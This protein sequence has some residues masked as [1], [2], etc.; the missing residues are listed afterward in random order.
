[1][2]WFDDLADPGIL[3]LS[4]RVTVRASE[5]LCDTGD[6]YPARVTLTTAEGEFRIDVPYARGHTARPL[7]EADL[8]AKL[9]ATAG[10][11]APALL[12]AVLDAPSA[13]LPQF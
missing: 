8:R 10:R 6:G 12:T 3:T 2:S 7:T 13:G 11:S 1:M 4:R 9:H 5:T